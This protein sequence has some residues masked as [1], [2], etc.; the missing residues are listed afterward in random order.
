MANILLCS[1]ILL[2]SA[3]TFLFTSNPSFKIIITYNIVQLFGRAHSLY[4][5]ASEAQTEFMQWLCGKIHF[6]FPKYLVNSTN[7]AL[8]Y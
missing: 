5:T 6:S 4:V 3:E 2:G 8:L 7:T 1:V